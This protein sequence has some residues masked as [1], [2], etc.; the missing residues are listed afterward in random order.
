MIAREEKSVV[1]QKDA[2]SFGVAWR[3]NGE[4]TRGQLPWP[5][6]IENDFCVWLRG[7]L[8]PVNNAAAAEMFGETISI[9]HVIS[10]REEDIGDAAESLQLLDKGRNK[11]R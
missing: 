1:K 5:I 9:S 6:A 4:E 10:M 8:I 11:L 7:Q 3:R 2:V